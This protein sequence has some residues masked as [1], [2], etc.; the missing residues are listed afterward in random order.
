[1]FTI[2]SKSWAYMLKIRISRHHMEIA[3]GAFM[4]AG[5]EQ[6][7]K[8]PKRLTRRAYQKYRWSGLGQPL[9]NANGKDMFPAYRAL[10]EARQC[11]IEQEDSKFGAPTSV[12]WCPA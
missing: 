1:M 10:Q 8:G 5:R 3:P 6:G 7:P 2:G 9:D 11:R 12:D 4:I